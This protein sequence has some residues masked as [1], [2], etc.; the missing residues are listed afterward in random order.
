[1]SEQEA[2]ERIEAYLSGRLGLEETARLEAELLEQGEVARLFSE[3]L[4]MRELLGTMPPDEAPDGLTA[5]I[6]A[7]LPLG[8]APPMSAEQAAEEAARGNAVLEKLGLALEGASWSVRGPAMAFSALGGD[9]GR[10]RAAA[11]PKKPFWRRAAGLVLKRRK[12][13]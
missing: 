13:K 3:E 10:R 11:P 1:M 12:K 7:A 2:L 6:E 4:M 9:S 8:V 5:R